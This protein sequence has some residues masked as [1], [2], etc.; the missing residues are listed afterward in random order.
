MQ[1]PIQQA[2]HPPKGPVRV[3]H[4]DGTL[5]VVDK[6]TGLLSVP[7]KAKELSDCLLARVERE[8][9]GALLV[10]RLDMD[11][12]GV[13]VFAQSKAAQRHLGLQFER[14]HI[15]KQ[16]LAEVDGIVREDRGEIALPLIADWPNRPLQKVCFETGKPALTAWEVLERRAQTTVLALY[17][18]TGRSHQ[19]RVHCKEI[20]R[21]IVGD[22]FYG[23]PPAERLMLHAYTLT[24]RHPEGGAP[25]TFTAPPPKAL[26]LG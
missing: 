5:L 17:P 13:M 21:P 16:Y 24:L 25:H 3:I 10:H 22:R 4:Q 11:T 2:Y 18:H 7:G 12:S 23:G 26:D 20:S 19:L 6:P 1:P 15:E 9:P 8:S 14:R